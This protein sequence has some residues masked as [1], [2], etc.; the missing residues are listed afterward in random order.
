[1]PTHNHCKQLSATKCRVVAEV[2]ISADEKLRMCK[3]MINKCTNKKL[4]F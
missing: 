4:N 3:Q 2:I 1:M